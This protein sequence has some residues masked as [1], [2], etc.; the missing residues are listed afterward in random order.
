MSQST[1]E[2]GIEQLIIH[3]GCAANDYQ[4]YT[5]EK[6]SML[7][8]RF[9]DMSP[10]CFSMGLLTLFMI[11]FTL[12]ITVASYFRGAKFTMY[13][14]INETALLLAQVS[15]TTFLIG[16]D[17]DY[18]YNCKLKFTLLTISTWIAFY[19]LETIFYSNVF[20]NA[21]IIY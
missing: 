12:V 19:I 16:W 10:Y 20:L 6:A 21:N 13:K 8:D 3:G 5:Y 18:A 9:T 2:R 17:V 15:I 11:L 1:R 7:Y 4:R 14:L